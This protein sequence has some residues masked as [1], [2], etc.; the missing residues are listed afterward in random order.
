MFPSPETYG[1]ALRDVRFR[2]KK[3]KKRPKL[4]KKFLLRFLLFSFYISIIF[5]ILF[6][7]WS[8]ISPSS[9]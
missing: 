8:E 5:L 6:I 9:N 4:N 3:Y 1:F 7:F 2:A